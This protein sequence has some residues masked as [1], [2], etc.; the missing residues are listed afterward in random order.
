MTLPIYIPAPKTVQEA[1]QQACVNERAAVLF[2]AG[3][4]SWE[5]MTGCQAG[6]WYLVTGPDGQ[7]YNVDP[8]LGYKCSCPF[9]QGHE[10]CKHGIAV[11]ALDA[12]MQA[13]R[14]AEEEADGRLLAAETVA[15]RAIINAGFRP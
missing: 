15:E 4:Y 13:E 5:R 6:P 3:G 8:L 10:F 9:W 2:T 12:D 7:T 14:Q 1:L 11:A